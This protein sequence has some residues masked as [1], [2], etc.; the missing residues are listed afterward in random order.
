VADGGRC[1]G[2]GTIGVVFVAPLQYR[3]LIWELEYLTH[4]MGSCL[5]NSVTNEFTK[6]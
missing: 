4:E 6:Y 3:R 2:S 5:V 1:G